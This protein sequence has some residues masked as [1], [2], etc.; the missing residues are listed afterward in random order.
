M[1]E[2]SV[3]TDRFRLSFF[4]YII[5]YMLDGFLP[6]RIDVLFLLVYA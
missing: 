5:E 6:F 4:F 2:R 1:V 3:G